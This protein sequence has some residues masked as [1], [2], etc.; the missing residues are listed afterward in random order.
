MFRY[1]TVLLLLILCS[2]T[3]QSTAK[4]NNQL[5]KIGVLAHRGHDEA[6]KRWTL[7]A[8]YL[9]RSI[10]G[11]DFIIKP[12]S[13]KSMKQAVEN[14]LVQFILTNPGNYVDIEANY[15]ATRIATLKVKQRDRAF[16]LFSA[17]IFT[18]HDRHEINKL[19]DL[20]DKSFM[21]VKRSSVNN[22]RASGLSVLTVQEYP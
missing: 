8:E 14:N 9:S 16:T 19:E 11:Y 17:V 13:L 4:N 12:K 10:K 3:F 15:G 18:R 5:I 22:F 7:T 2:L 20:R 1:F 6:L 21:A